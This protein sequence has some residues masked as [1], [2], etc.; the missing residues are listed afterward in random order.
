[1]DFSKIVNTFSNVM[2]KKTEL[3]F[4]SKLNLKT[5][6]VFTGCIA[7]ISLVKELVPFESVYL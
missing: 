1:M 6:F 7:T 3:R 5:G 4:I 2:L